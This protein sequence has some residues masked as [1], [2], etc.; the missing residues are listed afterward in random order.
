MVNVDQVHWNQPHLY[1]ELHRYNLHGN[2]KTSAG[3]LAPERAYYTPSNAAVQ[4]INGVEYAEIVQSV[5]DK[6][7]EIDGFTSNDL[8]LYPHDPFREPIRWKD[9]D[10]L[11]I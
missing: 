2:L 10:H 3:T 11:T 9:Y 7:F 6:F 8:M 5:A 4:E 1:S